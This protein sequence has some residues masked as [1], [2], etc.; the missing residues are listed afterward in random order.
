MR[1]LR[2][3][4]ENSN[5]TAPAAKAAPIC[6]LY[7][8]AEAVPYKDSSVLTDILRG[9]ILKLGLGQHKYLG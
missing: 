9:L 3:V 4:R 2:D 1:L 6:V 5:F 8:T 7:G